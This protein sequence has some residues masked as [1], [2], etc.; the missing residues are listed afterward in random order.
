MKVCLVYPPFNSQTLEVAATPPPLTLQTLASA[1][2]DHCSVKIIDA[3]IYSSRNAYKKTLQAVLRECPDV[4][5]ITSMTASFPSAVS[6][7]RDV[8]KAMPDCKIVMGGFHVTFLPEIVSSGF[9]DYVVRGEGDLTFKELINAVKKGKPVNNIKGLTYSVNSK[10]FS[11]PS[12]PLIKNLDDL[13]IPYFEYCNKKYSLNNARIGMMES[14]RGCSF[15]CSFCSIQNFYGRSWRKKSIN[16][17]IKEI[18]ILKSLNKK[19]LWFSDDNFALD[20]KRV[21]EICSNMKDYGLIMKGGLVQL[22][23]DSIV[24]NPE[25]VK[26]M[27]DVGINLAFLGIESANNKSLKAYHKHLNKD[28]AV[29]AVK[30]L[31]DHGIAS[32]GSFILGE[33]N[34]TEADIKR[35]INYASNLGVELGWFTVLT[36]FPGT[37]LMKKVKDKDLSDDWADYDVVTP[38]MDTKLSR[39]DLNKLLIKAY[40]SFYLRPAYFKHLFS[41]NFCV[42]TAYWQMLYRLFSM[43]NALRQKSKKEF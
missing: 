8:K 22:R 25:I 40:K 5:G 4:V 42:R 38:V 37:E 11:N 7:A 13:P 9:V 12:R 21:G 10:V 17:I 35:T 39:K 20:M 6:L 19:F 29:K 26:L 30:I 18:M 32:W 27:S 31:K 34:E 3:R 24:S 16:R 1:V 2:N 14:S 36:P 15:N 28:L 41:K 43:I 33:L 23:V